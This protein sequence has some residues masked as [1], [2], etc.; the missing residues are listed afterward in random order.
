MAS[1]INPAPDVLDSE[2][3]LYRYW[4]FRGI[5]ESCSNAIAA[6]KANSVQIFR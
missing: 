4:N 3:K 1:L 5:V 6:R 2:L